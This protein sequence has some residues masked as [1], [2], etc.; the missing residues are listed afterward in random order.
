MV[1]FEGQWAAGISVRE[2]F[3]KSLHAAYR[4]CKMMTYKILKTVS[5]VS[6]II[7]D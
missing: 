7:Q 6:E 4:D 3:W 2:L 1:T 5:Y